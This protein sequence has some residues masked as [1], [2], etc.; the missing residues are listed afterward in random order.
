MRFHVL[1]LAHTQTTK[2]YLSCA[3]TQKARNF[4]R[5]MI[6][7]GHEVYLY[8]GEQNDV[9]CTE[10]LVCISEKDR[11]AACNNGHFHNADHSPGATHWVQFN[12]QTIAHLAS[13]AHDGDFLCCTFG[14][15]HQMVA[16][17]MPILLPVEYGIGYHQ[18]FTKHRAFESYAWMHTVYGAE[19]KTSDRDGIFFDDVVS[20]VIDPSQFK[21]AKKKKDYLLYLGR[22][23]DRKGIDIAVQ[24]AKATGR[25]LIA[26][27]PGT[28]IKGMHYVGEVGVVQRAKLLSEAYAVLMPTKYIEPFGNVAI[29][30]MASGTP[31]ISTDWGAF[32]ETVI[33]AKTGYR[34]RVLQEFVDAVNHCKY[35]NSQAIRDHAL[36]H[37]SLDTI[38]ERYE[39]F[40]RRLQLLWGSGWDQLREGK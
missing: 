1:G 19:A 8:S 36:H 34:C 14:V 25:T 3:Y 21:L 26:A 29:E 39:C 38:S 24:V 23:I 10:H 15:A 37:Y 12:A 5:M 31:V 7:R 11:A 40:F 6:D 18:T 32:T 20:G 16:N 35:L 2:K 4:C 22:M 28:P 9:P 27:G 33:Q 17:M 30:A 13:R